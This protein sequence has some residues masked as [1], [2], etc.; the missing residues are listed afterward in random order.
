MS[1]KPQVETF[2][3]PATFTASYV[4]HDPATLSAAIIDPVLDYDHRAGRVWHRS[5]DDL[6]GFVAEQGLSVDWV[7]E[8]HAHADHLS[9]APY[10]QEKTGA[11]IGI[12]ARITEVQMGTTISDTM[13]PA[14]NVEEGKTPSD[15]P[16]SSFTLKNGTKPRLSA[17]HFDKVMR[18]G[19]R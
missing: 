3:D 15:V 16:K 11:P 7:L 12:G 10:L 6:L 17:S 9:A 14:T 18:R 19:C 13:T 2:F 4:V 1:S 5:A 8:T